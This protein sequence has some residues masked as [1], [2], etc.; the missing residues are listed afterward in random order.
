[1]DG[2]DEPHNCTYRECSNSQFRC[3]NQRCISQSLKCN[4]RNDCIDNSDEKAESCD[5]A[6]CPQ[7]QYTCKNKKCITNDL[8][9]NQQNDCE[10]N[11]DESRCGINECVS[12]ILNRCQHIC[13]DTLTS[14]ECLCRPGFKIVNKFYCVDINECTETPYVCSQLCEN[15]LG[16]YNCKCAPG[17]EKSSIGTTECKI[18]GPQIEANLLFSNSYYLR[19]LSLNTL[20]YNLIKDGFGLAKGIAYNYNESQIYLIDSYKRELIRLNLDTSLT[21]VVIGED[22]LLNDLMG[23]ETDI[24]FD[25][26]SKKIYYLNSNKL[27]VVDKNG[28]YKTALLDSKFLINA[29]SLSIDPIEGY[30]FISDSSFPPFIA[31]VKLNGENFT[32]IITQNL[33]SAVS[34]SLDLVTKR[35]FWTDTHLRHIEFS[36]YN[37]N[38][39]FI[40]IHTNQTAYPFALTYYQGMIYWTDLSEHSIYSANALNGKNKTTIRQSTAHMVFD[41]NVYHYSLQPNGHNP[42]GTNNGG[43]SHLCL[44]GGAPGSNFTCAC[45][46]S[47]VLHDDKKTCTANCGSWYFR[48]GMP[49]EKCVPFFFKCDGETD[50]RDGSDEL[51]CPRR[52]CPIGSFQC[53]N[54]QCISFSQLCNGHDDCMDG[55]DEQSCPDGCPPGRF[56]CPNKRCIPNYRV[57]DG[58]NDC[59]DSADELSC[60]NMTCPAGKFQCN[61]GHCIEASYYCDE[62]FDCADRSDEPAYTCRNRPCPSGWSRCGN[63]SYKCISKNQ[64]CDGYPDCPAGDDETEE[65]CPSCHPTGDFKCANNRCIMLSLRC[66]SVDDCGDNSDESSELCSTIGRRECTE[67]EFR[68]SNGHCIR[69]L[70]RCDHNDDCGDNSDELNCESHSCH[71]DQWQC[72]SGHCISAYQHCN[73]VRNCLD[74][75]DETSCPPKFPNGTYCNLFQFTCNNTFCIKS[76][77]MCDGDN[78]CG[79]NSDELLSLCSSYNCTKEKDRFRCKN[80][81]CIYAD[82]VCNG[83]SDCSDGSDEDFSINGPCKR[84]HLTCNEDQFKCALNHHCIPVEYVCDQDLDCGEDDQSDEIGCYNNQTI[85]TDSDMSCSS[86]SSLCEHECT[87]LANKNGFFCSCHHG[88]K[89]V[90][91][92]GTSSIHRHTCEDIDE[93]QTIEM[94]HCTH[95]CLNTKGSFECKCAEN[96]LDMHRDGSVCEA[97]WKE[98]YILLI[99]YGSEIRQ[100]RPNITDYVYS[101]L[102]EKQESVTTFDF[103]ILERHLYWIDGTTLKRSFIPRSRYSLATEQQLGD[104]KNFQIESISVDWLS[105]NV[106]LYDSKSK[107]IKVMKSDG[108]YLKTLITSF[109]GYVTNLVA[110]PLTGRLFWINSDP[111]HSIVSSRMNGEDIK[112]LV[113]SHLDHPYGLAIDFITNR[114][115]WSDYRRS[116]M[117]S[118]KFDGSDRSYFVHNG[119]RNPYSIDIFEN[120]VYFLARDSGAISSVDKYGR[121]AVN[122]LLDKL[123]LVEE[124]KVFHSFKI[125]KHKKNPCSNSSCSHL[126][127]LKSD[128]DYECSCPD[129]G[130]FLDGEVSTCDSA[131]EEVRESP[132]ACKCLNC[133]CWYNNHGVHQKCLPGWK[134][135]LCDVNSEQASKAIVDKVKTASLITIPIVVIAILVISLFGLYSY[136]KKSERSNIVESSS[137]I[138]SFPR[139]PHN[140]EIT[141]TEINQP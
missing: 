29:V 45:P 47:F 68:C 69:D 133:W 108:R 56:E 103:D 141:P 125:P 115:Y 36:D 4:G 23:D 52:T 26:I 51:N 31:R 9:C 58:R 67:S 84:E 110:N 21:N 53:N 106:Y 12:P 24:G 114:L 35:I 129:D 111:E 46:E 87:N 90:K 55:S 131:L 99:A 79:D 86:N 134:G 50:C 135:D 89:M 1:G 74:F 39:R 92:N 54:S 19:N 18:I 71:S 8:V 62:D 107:S 40:A 60:A 17:Y 113:T 139:T 63:N 43:C 105:K 70:W 121:G 41:M 123:D 100:L 102:I 82:N 42:C 66:N 127:L 78:D 109:C 137:G 25:W 57:C 138:T 15:T 95:L 83:F 13:R 88:F 75:S 112:L 6:T 98:D 14:Y 59:G 49:D 48:C 132:L 104:F 5:N 97:S 27:V 76:D 7:G 81:L 37:G 33:G 11:S 93:C 119:L 80:G 44:I 118:V 128:T 124:I 96:Y 16:S 73:G 122:K 34:L 140:S 32:K 3:D 136:K 10:D 101:T 117:E 85:K 116:M 22:V 38:N 120:K 20:N 65:K 30:I 28:H 126:C 61:S 2:S 72:K 94:N 91:A 64:F 77:Y 130:K